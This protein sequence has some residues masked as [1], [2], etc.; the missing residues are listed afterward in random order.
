MSGIYDVNGNLISESE[1][2]KIKVLGIGNSYTRDSLRWLWK[3]LIELGYTE[4]TV[5]HGYWGASTLA[6]QYA[7]RAST[8]FE[9]WKYTTS[10]N[11]T[12]T[13]SKTLSYILADEPWD[14]VIFQQQ[15]DEAGQYSSFVS[16]DF[17]INDFVTHVKTSISNSKLRIGIA[18]TW[19]H[20]T[21]YTG[22]KFIQY[23]G[24]DPAVQLAAIKSVIPQVANHMSQCNCV[25][26]VGIAIEQGRL[27]TYL[28][29]LGSQMLRS[30]KNHLQYGIPSYMAGLVYA[31][32]ICN[33]DITELTWYPTA[34]DEGES[35]TTS[36]YLAYLAKQCARY[37]KE[38]FEH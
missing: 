6:Q 2:K 18:L 21:G 37:A 23:Y 30:D 8:S 19:S 16:S 29:A 34:T 1:P 4:V 12:K 27:N 35:C 9:Y 11:A 10:Q 24:G 33:V 22:D 32:T 3:I 25:V 15:S 5:G 28:N 20:S 38:F 14:V 13:S 36:Q 17:D 31:L 26:N 7:S